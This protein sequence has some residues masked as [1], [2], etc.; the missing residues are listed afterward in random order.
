MELKD[1]IELMTSDDYKDRFRAEYWQTKIRY[2][3][4]H[5][6]HKMLVRYDAGTLSFEPT[7]ISLLREQAAAMWNYLY[8][9]EIRAEVEKIEL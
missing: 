9:L 8:Y 4:L 2:D 5:K 3:K 6:L 1:T 7:N